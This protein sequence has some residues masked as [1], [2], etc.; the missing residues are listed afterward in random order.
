[1]LHYGYVDAHDSNSDFKQIRMVCKL[2]FNK[3]GLSILGSQKRRGFEDI[4]LLSLVRIEV[5]LTSLRLSIHLP[6]SLN[7]GVGVSLVRN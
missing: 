2:Q 5:L 1:M 4:V 3:I 7:Q 6:F